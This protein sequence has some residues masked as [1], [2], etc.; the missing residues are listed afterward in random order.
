MVA[1]L[2]RRLPEY[3]DS[4]CDVWRSQGYVPPELPLPAELELEAAQLEAGVEA[5]AP[6]LTPVDSEAPESLPPPAVT[7]EA[8]QL[9]AEAPELA[10]ID[11]EVP[12][13]LP[14][15]VE[16]GETLGPQNQ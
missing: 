11:S 6:E 16:A 8:A 2:T 12:V 15:P 3:W 7:V 4:I 1:S 5:E 14:P 13:S 10:L 9:E